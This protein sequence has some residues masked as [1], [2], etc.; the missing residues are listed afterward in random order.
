MLDEQIFEVLKL[1]IMEN[2]ENEA[3]TSEK[4]LDIANQANEEKTSK[5]GKKKEAMR[6]LK[7]LLCSISAGVIQI[8]LSTVLELL[9]KNWWVTYLIPLVASVIWNFTFNRKFTF[10]SANNVPIAMLLVAAYYAVFTPLSLWW[11]DLLTKAGWHNL[12]VVAFNMIINFVTEFLYQRFVVFRK[13]LDTAKSK[14][15]D[16]KQNEGQK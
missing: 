10:K 2:E 1:N 14:K 5:T 4:S 3:E 16:V 6:A 9:T 12:L 8:V 11:G 7:F 15:K 13:S